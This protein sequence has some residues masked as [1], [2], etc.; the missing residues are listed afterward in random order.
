MSLKIMLTTSVLTG[1]GA[2]RVV[3]VW[4]SEL[5]EKGYDISL[6]LAGRTENEY[7]LSDK[8][9]VYTIAPT[10]SAYQNMSKIQKIL[11]RHSVLKSVR[12]DYL[13]SFLP[14]IQVLSLFTSVGLGIKRIETVRISPWHAEYNHGLN[15]IL[16]KLCFET[17]SGI[18][19][20]SKDQAGYFRKAVQK[21]CVV[22]PNP[23]SEIYETHYKKVFQ[24]NVT[25]LIAAGRL[26]EQ[27]NYP[28]M[29]DA[30][31]LAMGQMQ[32][33]NKPI[34]KIFGA[35]DSPDYTE[36]LRAY[37]KEK[38]MDKYVH[39]MGRS[40]HIEDEYANADV[41][42]MSSDF[43]GMPNALAE[44]MAS[45]LVCISTDCKTGP[46]DLI[47]HGQNGYLVPVGDA[48]A[49]A[50]AIRKV[51][52]MSKQQRMDIG[53]LARG[54]IMTY[55]SQENSIEKICDLLGE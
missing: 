48:T 31:A 21:K 35:E 32:M 6:L 51:C 19:I 49:M 22:I 37:I 50:E 40:S 1:G 54:K 3:S 52:I 29:I 5:A 41:F 10:Y 34:L 20:Q 23:I 53:D 15:K 42:L 7:S 16:W 17:G 9:K 12:P 27:K 44:A 25:T 24:D 43:E 18:I 33:A 14:H 39:L 38:G 13:I 2:E 47:D 36:K 28:M 55:C 30:F 26:T 45:K 46:R 4:A 11:G 8:V